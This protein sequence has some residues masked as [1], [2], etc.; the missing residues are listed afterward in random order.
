[1]ANA[2]E[3]TSEGRPRRS[4]ETGGAAAFAA[5]A[6]AAGALV[7][8]GLTAGELRSAVIGAPAALAAA[9]VLR[10]AEG[11]RY[12]PR[13]LAAP[14]FAIWLLREIFVSAW[15]VA[16]LLLA[17]ELRIAPGVLSFPLRL[18]GDGARAAFMNAVTLTPGTLSA[19][20]SGDRLDVHALD[21]DAGLAASLDALEVRIARLYGEPIAERAG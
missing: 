9:F 18:R 2:H 20:L 13:A 16:R 8:F 12:A 14:G 10:S 19:G 7:W 3:L 4:R 1:M 5:L 11:R 6:L 21:M 15:A 17:R